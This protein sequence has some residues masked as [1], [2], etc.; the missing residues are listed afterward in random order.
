MRINHLSL[1]ASVFL[2]GFSTNAMAQKT[3]QFEG[4]KICFAY[5]ADQLEPRNM[6]GTCPADTIEHGDDHCLRTTML[7]NNFTFIINADN[8]M[9]F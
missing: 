3:S 7:N 1:L 9:D 6:D 4:G 2:L 8:S 5:E